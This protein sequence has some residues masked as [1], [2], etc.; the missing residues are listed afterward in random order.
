MFE[1][2]IQKFLLESQTITQKVT[3]RVYTSPPRGNLTFPCII[4]D[5]V[6]AKLKNNGRSSNRTGAC[7]I[8]VVASTKNGAHLIRKLIM[9]HILSFDPSINDDDIRLNSLYLSDE[10][11][12]VEVSEKSVEITINA[13]TT[14]TEEL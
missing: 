3:K 8:S 11:Y 7:E 5:G 9:K 13:L 10:G 1:D 4:I 12:S 6:S 14:F 2:L